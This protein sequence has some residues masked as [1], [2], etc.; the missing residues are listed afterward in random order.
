MDDGDC[1]A[2]IAAAAAAVAHVQNLSRGWFCGCGAG[3]VWFRFVISRNG[4][5]A[6]GGGRGGEETKAATACLH[7]PRIHGIDLGTV[8]AEAGG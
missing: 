8:A 3:L 6:G 7:P 5:V 2:A 1:D 4:L